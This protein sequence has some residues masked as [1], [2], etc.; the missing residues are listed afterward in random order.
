MSRRNCNNVGSLEHHCFAFVRQLM[1][2]F[3]LAAL[4][5]T[6]VSS[7]SLDLQSIAHNQRNCDLEQGR[8]S[9]GLYASKQSPNA[10]SS[11]TARDSAILVEWEQTSELQRRIEDGINYEHWNEDEILGMEE[12]V[13]VDGEEPASV[14]GVFFGYRMTTEERARLKSAHPN[15]A[16]N[17]EI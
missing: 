15:E 1:L 11:S 14:R 13:T 16:M 6:L 17:Y 3:G 10:R 4:S 7:F 9:L 2:V 5:V 12:D 8:R